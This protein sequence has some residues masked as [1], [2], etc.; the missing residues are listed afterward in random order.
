M[1]WVAEDHC[2]AAKGTASRN[3]ESGLDLR[4]RLRGLQPGAYAKSHGEHGSGAVS[5]GRS[6][7]RMVPRWVLWR[8]DSTKKF[9][10]RPLKTIK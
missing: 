9:R 10:E 5:P 2:F 4:L 8:I 3:I 1:L 6:V 7:L